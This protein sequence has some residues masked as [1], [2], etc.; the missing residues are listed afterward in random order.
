MCT[1]H[2]VPAP[3]DRSFRSLAESP[4]AHPPHQVDVAHSTAAQF[5]QHIHPG[6]RSFVADVHSPNTSFRPSKLIPIATY[7][8]VSTRFVPH[9]HV[10]R[11]QKH[12]PIERRRL[13]A[14]VVRTTVWRRPA[15]R[16]AFSTQRRARA[17]KASSMKSTI[18]SRYRV[19]ADPEDLIHYEI[20]MG[21]I[22]TVRY[23]NP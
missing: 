3:P 9:L 5:R 21:Q 2:T 6:L 7:R 22:A 1:M 10:Q 12:H 18:G 13:P 17:W 23:G 11:I 4:R 14:R 20:G 8:A 15:N 19:D 16:S